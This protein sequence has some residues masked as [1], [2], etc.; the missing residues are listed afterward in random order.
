MVIEQK[1][2]DILQKDYLDYYKVFD[3]GANALWLNTSRLDFE[4]DVWYN[5]DRNRIIRDMIAAQW[6]GLKVLATGTGTGAH[7]WVDNEVL[8]NLGA[9][10][11]I[12]TN[13]ILGTGIDI[14]CDACELPF[15]DESFDA[16]FCREVIEHVLDANA[17]LYEAR[18]V[19]KQNGWF[20]LTTPNGFNCLP[21]GTNHIRA[22]TPQSFIAHV[23][24]Y[25]FNV[26]EKRGNLPNV[27]VSLL[28]LIRGGCRLPI[29][30]EYQRLS[31]MWAQVDDSY[32]FGSE[33][34]LLCRR[35]D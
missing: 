2:Q 9:K 7:Q 10:Q 21:D 14:A 19:L 8:D 13:L 32:Y 15:G 4:A 5:K 28:P 12:K 33:L 27:W 16:I 25:K 23:E 30:E 24:H 34:Y 29:L 6:A 1:D 31:V 3:V 18:R 17:L 35:R 26:I 22:Y 20:M 11:V